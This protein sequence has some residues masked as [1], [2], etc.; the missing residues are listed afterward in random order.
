MASRHH[1]YNFHIGFWSAFLV[2]LLLVFQTALVLLATS[3]IG[4]AQDMQITITT[5][6][7][8]A[9]YDQDALVSL[10][11]TTSEAALKLT[12]DIIDNTT[13]VVIATAQ[14]QSVDYKNWQ[15]SWSA[16]QSGS[17]K[18]VAESGNFSSATPINIQVGEEAL[19]VALK[20]PTNNSNISTI[21]TFHAQTNISAD[22]VSFNLAAID[23]S[24]NTLSFEGTSTDKINWNYSFDPNTEN[25]T[26]GD[27]DVVAVAGE[28]QSRSSSGEGAS[29]IMPYFSMSGSSSMV[30]YSALR[31]AVTPYLP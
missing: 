30:T 15:S 24:V 5:P 25:I 31:Y 16:R 21:T 2:S 13:G 19:T 18:I 6:T 1:I 20:S 23:G 9:K 11:A 3:G 12:F 28:H 22:S 7:E 27:Y 14:G 17:F 26:E 10:A 8:G 29:S 4:I